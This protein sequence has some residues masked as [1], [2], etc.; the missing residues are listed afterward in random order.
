MWATPIGSSPSTNQ[1][2]GTFSKLRGRWIFATD[3]FHF[4][5]MLLPFCFKFSIINNFRSI[6]NFQYCWQSIDHIENV[7]PALH[8][9]GMQKT[10]WLSL[11]AAHSDSWLFGVAFYYGAQ[12]G[13]NKSDRERL[14]N[15]I[16][17]L[18]KILEVVDAGDVV[19]KKVDEKSSVFRWSNLHVIEYQITVVIKNYGQIRFQLTIIFNYHNYLIFNYM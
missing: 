6:D 14:F 3:S 5:N 18:P 15:M 7:L 17:E 9:S 11:V 12:F 13:F 2:S 1:L 8:M 4:P 19:K 16:S 10:D